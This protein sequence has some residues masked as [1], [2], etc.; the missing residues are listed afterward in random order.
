MPETFLF[1]PQ[2]EHQAGPLEERCGL[3]NE[4]CYSCLQDL[5]GIPDLTD[6]GEIKVQGGVLD[7]NCVAPDSAGGRMRPSYALG[8]AP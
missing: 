5:T 3:G 1:S 8:S 6:Q 2:G 4:V 7:C